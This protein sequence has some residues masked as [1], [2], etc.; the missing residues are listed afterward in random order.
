[1]RLHAGD[2]LRMKE[3]FLKLE[4]QYK[5]LTLVVAASPDSAKVAKVR[6]QHPFLDKVYCNVDF[7]K[8]FSCL[9]LS[10]L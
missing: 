8:S 2:T 10:Y 1:M 3:R 4:N 9:F 6:Q 5:A 7:T